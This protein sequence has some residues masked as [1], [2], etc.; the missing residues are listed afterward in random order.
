MCLCMVA[1]NS[2]SQ[3]HILT[4]LT[5][6][7]TPI[8][9]TTPACMHQQ[10]TLHNPIGIMGVVREGHIHHHS[11]LHNPAVMPIAIQGHMQQKHE[12]IACNSHGRVCSSQQPLHAQA[13]YNLHTEIQHY[14]NN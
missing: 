2:T 3:R 1:T 6:T 4:M 14:G 12:G 13:R 10:Q 11:V 7:P 9:T 5:P 8:R